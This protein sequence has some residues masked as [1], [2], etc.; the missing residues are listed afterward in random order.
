[1]S[2]QAPKL[3]VIGVF[4]LLAAGV[5]V[6]ALSRGPMVSP[7]GD[8]AMGRDRAGGSATL[9][10]EQRQGQ[11]QGT[12]APTSAE[13]AV[14]I[15]VVFST[16]KEAWLAE[17]TK[18]FQA[19][20]PGIAVQL[21]GQGSL[22]AVRAILDG[23]SQPTVWSPADQVALNVLSADWR[24]KHRTDPFVN[25][26]EHK[27]Q[28]LVL[29]PLVYVAWEDRGRVLSEEQGGKTVTWRKLQR[30]LNTAEG[31]KGIGGSADW[32]FIKLGHTDP[33]KSNSG[34]QALVLMAYEYHQKTRDLEVADI[35]D[36]EFQ[37]FVKSIEN[38]VPNFGDSTGT[39]MR[40]MILYGPSKYDL[41]V[42]YENLAIE[43][44]SNAQGRWG[45]LRIYYPQNTVWSDH[46][47]AVFNAP[48]VSDAQRE[49]GL[50]F[51]DFLLTPDV[52]RRA[53][54]YGFRPA[55]PS[56]PIVG[57]DADNPFAAA[58]GYGV[59]IG[60]PT[61]VEAPPGPVIRNLIEMWS[62]QV[63]RR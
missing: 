2:S 45:N 19:A 58:K 7:S 37:E 28:P 25:D 55:D 18:A 3:I 52:Q 11:G 17:A 12:N 14:E 61:A 40:D 48:W 32:G 31:W 29:T 36:A 1:M 30:I 34:V 49:A 50:R 35:V 59:E 62:R 26:G 41:V 38:A 33:R 56:I 27:P 43:Q 9:S 13:A 47:V 44:L 63:G 15:E 51:V 53:L 46:P 10:K 8:E 60:L 6:F 5:A 23:K 22:D 20:N 24:Q 16:E 21:R 42:T 39:F 54:R 4:L 57:N